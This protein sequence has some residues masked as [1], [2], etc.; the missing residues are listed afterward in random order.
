MY[1]LRLNDINYGLRYK[2]QNVWALSSL[3]VTVPEDQAALMCDRA[4]I[5]MYLLVPLCAFI[6]TKV[7]LSV[8][9]VIPAVR[10]ASL[11]YCIARG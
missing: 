2:H 11:S 6:N 5:H 8:A 3:T 10:Y 1:H 9:G 7:F 4:M